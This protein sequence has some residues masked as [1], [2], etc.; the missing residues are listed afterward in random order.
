MISTIIPVETI[1]LLPEIEVWWKYIPPY[2]SPANKY[3]ERLDPDADKE[4]QILEV[5]CTETGDKL[6]INEREERLIIH[7]LSKH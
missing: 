4:Y 1:D 7:Y 3:G 5:Y 6:D 2:I